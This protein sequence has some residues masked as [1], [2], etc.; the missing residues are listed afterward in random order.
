MKL[1]NLKFVKNGHYSINDLRDYFSSLRKKHEEEQ[2]Y[3][4]SVV[5]VNATM[6]DLVKMYKDLLNNI[7]KTKHPNLH[8][9]IENSINKMN[10]SISSFEKILD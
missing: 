1:N 2:E 3:F 10:E 7:D 5:S 6:K 8:Y 9:R 4:Q